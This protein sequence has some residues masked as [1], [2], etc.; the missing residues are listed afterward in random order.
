VGMDVPW[1]YRNN[2]QFGVDAQGRLSFQAAGSNRL[3]PVTSCA[4]L[5][6]LLSEMAFG[7]EPAGN[8]AGDVPALLSSVGG[9][10]GWL[11]RVS[12][13]AGIHTGDRLVILEV[14]GAGGPP[15]GP[16][17]A[18]AGSLA[19]RLGPACSVVLL[20]EEGRPVTLAGRGY[21]EERLS[22]RAF[23]VSAAS[24]FQV[25]TAQAEKLA[26]LVAAYA[27]PHGDETLLDCFCGVGTFGLL[28]AGRVAR[29]IGVEESPSAVADARVNAAG[30]ANV[31]LRQ[32]TAEAVLPSLR[33]PVH[34]AIV[35][36]PRQGC[37]PAALAAL[38]RLGPR[39]IV[40]VSCDPATLAR[41]VLR[42]A[43]AGY[44]LREA[45]PVDMFPQTYHV[46][47]VALL[48]RG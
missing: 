4:I 29:V 12:L 36:P 26:E 11:H 41:D 25:N 13:R 7:P 47:T 48:E 15:R 38:A 27:D 33:Q 2:A 34:L 18:W 10:P 35:D 43:A 23:R 5:H 44:I 46:E 31:T 40:Y 3:V 14:A 20:P 39:R 21:L 1:R 9:K 45:T 42:L 6:P 17:E 8:L 24:F 19:S 22:G 30:L 32:G 28:L 37:E 16:L